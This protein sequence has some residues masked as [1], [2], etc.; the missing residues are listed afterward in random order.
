MNKRIIISGILL[1]LS[2]FSTNLFTQVTLQD[3]NLYSKIH[4]E[5]PT[6]DN[7]DLLNPDY[8]TFYKKEASKGW[9]TKG[10]DS[11]LC[12]LHIKRKPFWSAEN[13]KKLLDKFIKK[14]DMGDSILA[15]QP[16]KESKFIIFGSLHGAFH[17][18]T[19][20]LEKLKE[21]KIIDDDLKITDDYYFVFN[22]NLVDYSPYSLEILYT[23]LILMEKNQ[24][25]VFYVK[26]SHEAG[27]W[28]D[29]GL[30][31]EIDIRLKDWTTG[32]KDF[33]KENI[34]LFFDSLPIAVFLKTLDQEEF[35]C[36]SYFD[37]G[38]ENLKQ[39]YF[40]QF[41]NGNLSDKF[42]RF[43]LSDI[44]E[45][46]DFAKIEAIVKG[47]DRTDSYLSTKGLIQL[48]PDHGA[49]AWNVLSS[50]TKSYQKLYNFFYDAFAIV[51]V[52]S[53][54]YNCKISLFNRNIKDKQSK[55]DQESYY[56][57]SSQST[58]KPPCSG[59]INVGS[60]MGL[61]G[62]VASKGEKLFHG[63]FLPL[64]NQNKQGG[65][66]GKYIKFTVFDDAY[67]PSRAKQ[68]I[69]KLLSKYQT[70]IILSPLGSPTLKFYFD[71]VKNKEILVLF[72]IGA[73]RVFRQPNI[74]YIVHFRTSYEEETKA[75]IEYAVKD[76]NIKNKFAIFYQNDTYGLGSYNVSRSLLS[77][78]NAQILPL[79]YL[80]G[81]SDF[82]ELV[83]N[84]LEFKPK[85]LILVSTILPT[86]SLIRQLGVKNL[87]KVKII[88]NS[89]LA[90]SSFIN[91]MRDKG[92]SFCVTH[93]LPNFKSSDLEIVKLYKKLSQKIGYALSEFALEGYINSSIFV[94][95]ANKIEGE[96]TKEK[97]LKQIEN[98]KNY[99]LEGLKL[100]FNPQ[101]RSL[102][103][104]IWIESEKGERERWKGDK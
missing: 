68:N 32:Q 8:T 77:K 58:N 10:W 15:A 9:I 41:L 38:K 13:L 11:V 43:N 42:Q 45:T 101:T 100:N 23:V 60:T 29:N 82:N 46:N 4:K 28:Y 37:L 62:V 36:F 56:L 39:E 2:I 34:G 95:V 55:F 14:Q 49:T 66:S 75:I 86:M 104:N 89:I 71:M 31:K 98:I 70:S 44:D 50:P 102:S 24:G 99:N 21:L 64:L 35:V 65:I 19:R 16:K 61:T 25:K 93:V 79:P 87:A 59:R 88:G 74:N 91:F 3:L 20:D 80:T 67:E 27:A 6:Y 92:L 22:G 57:V 1:Y 52:G 40:A 51:E 84:V 83:N 90:E 5:F 33:L 73:A 48:L 53:D 18:F 96:V 72:S 85:S 69:E 54:I 63:T 47:V 94:D 30:R 26:G 78:Y 76:L 12:F 17:S 7:K 81:D 103:D 97:V